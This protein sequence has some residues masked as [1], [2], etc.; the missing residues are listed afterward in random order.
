MII[1]VSIHIRVQ[2]ASHREKDATD[3]T[4]PHP[5]LR[6]F[7]RDISAVKPLSETV[8][9]FPYQVSFFILAES[10]KDSLFSLNPRKAATI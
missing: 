1:M 9:A 2:P 7:G 6:T 10:T 4:V 5:S 3:H 8:D